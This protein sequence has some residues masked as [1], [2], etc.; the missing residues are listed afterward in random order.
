MRTTKEI[1]IFLIAK[2]LPNPCKNNC[3]TEVAKIMGY[4]DY[5]GK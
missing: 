5:F 1:R 2:F 3:K 4:F